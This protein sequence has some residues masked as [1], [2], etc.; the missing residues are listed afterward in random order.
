MVVAVM[1]GVAGLVGL[2]VAA[3]ASRW[4]SI[5]APRLQP[6]T[7]AHEVDEHP[8]LLAHLRHHYSPK[9]ETGVALIAATAIGIGGILAV[10]GLLAMVDNNAGF[11][12][13]D[14]RF[15]QFGADHASA[16]TTRVLKDVSLLFGSSVAVITLAVGITAI[17]MVRKPARALPLFVAVAIGGELLINN[18]I[19]FVVGRARPDVLQLT[20]AAGSSFPSGHTCSAAAAMAT[21]ALVLGR[22]RSR[23]TRIVLAGVA[24]AL[25]ASVACSRVFLGVHWFTD[26]LAGLALGWAWFA[27]CSIAFGGR[28]LRFGAPVE[29]AELAAD[30]STT[31]AV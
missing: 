27:L 5:E 19:K 4:P 31:R 24:A 26:V 10:G 30:H 15:A 3:I 16:W 21:F 7:I 29:T 18:T 1:L 6:A 20:N 11:A 12:R 17:E 22:D 23:R 13:L 14:A 8:S 2:G 28:L 9:T 25:A